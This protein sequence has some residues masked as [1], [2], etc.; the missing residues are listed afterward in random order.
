MQLYEL[1]T[2]LGAWGGRSA[3]VGG[4]LKDTASHSANPPKETMAFERK[5]QANLPRID[6]QLKLKTKKALANRDR[7]K[8]LYPIVKTMKFRYP[9]RLSRLFAGNMDNNIYGKSDYNL[10]TVNIQ[11]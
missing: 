6:N 1:T 7:G 4:S 11:D 3:P 2:S 10:T 5:L 9:N 8:Y